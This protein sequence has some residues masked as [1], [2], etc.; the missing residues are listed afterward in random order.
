[1]PDDV[2]R[3]LRR[4]VQCRRFTVK[5]K[6]FNRLAL[7]LW[8]LVVSIVVLGGDGSTLRVARLAALGLASFVA[9]V[10]A[11]CGGIFLNVFEQPLWYAAIVFLGA[12]LVM[13]VFFMYQP[14]A[15]I[16][17]KEKEINKELIFATRFLMI[18]I[19]SGV[20][21]FDAMRNLV[22]N[23]EAIGRQ[24]SDVLNMVNLGT[25]LEDAI[26]QVS[27]RT[28]SMALRKVLWQI[29]NSLKTGAD[30]SESLSAAVDQI[31]REQMIEVNEYGR[32]LNPI[33]MFYM[34]LA[35]ILP[36]IGIAIGVLVSNF[37]ALPLDLTTLLVLSGFLA[38]MQFM[39]LQMIRGMR[40][41]V[42]I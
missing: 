33:A 38:F 22:V 21:L 14:D 4:A 18:E 28:P 5:A 25:A 29:L 30:I 8:V 12:F 3:R 17:Q 7:G 13:R 32:K 15:M 36:S 34:I 24:F 2:F 40:P 23:Y 41:A 10:F 26:E 1:M 11:V 31:T 37:I 35:V 9:L 42:D 27:E 16:K 39:F 20:S 19:R 6:A